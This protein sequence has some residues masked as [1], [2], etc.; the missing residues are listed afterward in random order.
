M[1]TQVSARKRGPLRWQGLSA[2]HWAPRCESWSWWE[3][4]FLPLTGSSSAGASPSLPLSFLPSSRSCLSCSCLSH[5]SGGSQWEDPPR[6]PACLSC[7]LHSGHLQL[8]SAPGLGH[9]SPFWNDRASWGPCLSQECSKRLLQ[10][11]GQRRDGGLLGAGVRP[12][13]RPRAPWGGRRPLHTPGQDGSASL[14]HLW[15]K[16]LLWLGPAP[17]SALFLGPCS[18]EPRG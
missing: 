2:G 12:R 1:R 16:A 5:G 14:P 3:G 13:P 11:A 10:G 18:T 15:A 7:H 8:R 9:A 6:P 17:S 4:A